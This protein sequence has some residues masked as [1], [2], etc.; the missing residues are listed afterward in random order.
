MNEP[1]DESVF[2]MTR[3]LR[4]SY[5]REGK[6]VLDLEAEIPERKGAVL[7]NAYYGRL[8]RQLA[9]YC[10]EELVPDLPDRAQPLKLSLAYQVRLIT[11]SLL[12]LTLDL[13][14][15]DDRAMP[16]ARFGTVWSRS[17]GVPIPLRAFFPKPMGL[18]R[19]L[20]EWIR[21]QALERLDSGYCLYDPQ[22]ADRAGKLFSPHNFYAAERG[23]V[24][25]FPPLTLG[26]AAEGI[27][28]FLLP[29]DPAGPLPPEK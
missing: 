22:Q 18:H 21:A 11:P 29:W 7:L 10:A 17:A 6:A 12:S 16:A 15:R 3:K 26:S 28:E 5:L 2:L 27:P 24:L 8:F 14:R 25:F 13:V 1:E 23:L 9:G 4:R 20:R 19:R